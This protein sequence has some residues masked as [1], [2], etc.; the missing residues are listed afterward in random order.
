MKKRYFRITILLVALLSLIII[1]DSISITYAAA[2]MPGWSGS[3][4]LYGINFSPFKEDPNNIENV[5]DVDYAQSQ[6]EKLIGKVTWIRLFGMDRN[7]SKVIKIAKKLGF[8]VAA[9]AWIG[10]DVEASKKEVAELIKQIKAKQVDL[11]IVGN[12]VI[13]NQISVSQA[14]LIDYINQ[15]KKA[16]K[17]SIPVTTAATSNIWIA[18]PALAKAV[19]VIG[20]NVYPF[21]A[22][23]EIDSALQDFQATYSAVKKKAGGKQIVI[24]ETGWPTDGGQNGDAVASLNNAQQ[25][26][27]EITDYAR[28]E[29]IPLFCFEA[30]DEEWKSNYEGE[31]GAH[32]GIFDADGNA[33]LTLQPTVTPTPTPV[34]KPTATP[35][36]TPKPTA[37]PTPAPIPEPLGITD[38][39]YPSY[40]ESGYLSGRVTGIEGE[41]Y[42]VTYLFVEG[43]WWEKP[44]DYYYAIAPASDGTFMIDVD[45]GGTDYNATAYELYLL[46][47]KP[48]TSDKATVA[49]MAIYTIHIDRVN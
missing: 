49:Y 44:H 21:W 5:A 13:E 8:K 6:L 7:Q 46:T 29:K 23:T 2:K 25:Y 40:G 19:D 43:N 48:Q 15:V 47:E 16:A 33:K 45:T 12:E 24:T 27:D 3:K 9:G 1:A 14:E 31:F 41:V 17:G 11:A 4:P 20:L 18:C 32:W 28:E 26:M 37:T 39:E 30:F 34:P 22:E 38:I 36:P 35:T 42:V 10:N